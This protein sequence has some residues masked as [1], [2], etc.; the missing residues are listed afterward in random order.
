MNRTLVCPYVREVI[1]GHLED[2]L[3]EK[4]RKTWFS[5]TAKHRFWNSLE[6]VFDYLLNSYDILDIN[7]KAQSA[8]GMSL[9]NKEEADILEEYLNFFN[10]TFE[11][12]MPDDYYENHS[13]WPKLLEEARQIIELLEKNNKE[14]NLERD[15]ELWDKELAHEE[16]LEICKKIDSVESFSP[17]KKEQLKRKILDS[18]GKDDGHLIRNAVHDEVNKAKGMYQELEEK[19]EKESSAGL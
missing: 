11:G 1:I 2:L 5:T 4:F 3:D 6:L 14:Y 10:D 8:I 7:M 17:E 9:Y 15:M 16:F 18:Q 12:E 13:E 19:Y